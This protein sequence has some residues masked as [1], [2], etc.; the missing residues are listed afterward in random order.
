MQAV[1]FAF[2]LARAS[3]GSS[4]LASIAMMAMTTSN[5]INVNAGCAVTGSRFACRAVAI[6]LNRSGERLAKGEDALSV[7][8]ITVKEQESPG[9]ENGVRENSFMQI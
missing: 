6:F 3:A 1:R 4:I 2:S 7:A 8:P 5:S 9:P